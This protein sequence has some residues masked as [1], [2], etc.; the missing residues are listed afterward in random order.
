MRYCPVPSLTTVRVFSMSAGLDA[1]TL[2]PGS[3]AFDASRTTPAIV[4]WANTKLGSSKTP[5]TAATTF[6]TRCIA[7]LHEPSPAGA[8]FGECRQSA[9]QLD[10]TLV[11]GRLPHLLAAD[12]HV[13][14]TEIYVR[15]AKDQLG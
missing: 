5:A 14:R 3:T 13:L 9:D 12:R 1:S 15:C 4:A 2:T 8:V 11:P 10:G 7:N 6:T